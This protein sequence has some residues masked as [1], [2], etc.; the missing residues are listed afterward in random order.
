MTTGGDMK[1]RDINGR[2]RLGEKKI[3][4]QREEKNS[5]SGHVATSGLRPRWRPYISNP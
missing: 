3:D 1:D 5:R 2:T 4:Q